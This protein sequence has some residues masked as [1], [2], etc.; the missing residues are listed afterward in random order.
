MNAR[1]SNKKIPAALAEAMAQSTV[2]VV[3][4]CKPKKRSSKVKFKEVW[5]G[6]V[7]KVA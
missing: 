7:L 6:S 4:V 3:T 2:Q 5:S 1:F